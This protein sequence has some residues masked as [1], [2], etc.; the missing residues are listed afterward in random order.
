[1]LRIT[2]I[3]FAIAVFGVSCKQDTNQRMY[4]KKD[5]DLDVT[6]LYDFEK[7]PKNKI[8]SLLSKYAIFKLESDLSVLTPNERKMLPLLFEAGDIMGE[9]FW[10]EA[11]GNKDSL[12]RSIQDPSVKALTIINYGPWERLG[13]NQSFVEG[14][15]PKPEGANFYPADMTKDEFESWKDSTKTSQY[16]M[17]RRNKKGEL[18]SIPYHI[19]F[20]KSIKRASFL[21]EQASILADD[22]G[23]K[24]YLE[25][26]AK[27]LLSDDYR[28]SDLAWME[29]K[30]NRIDV[31]VGPIENYEDHL[32]G[33]KASHECYILIK[34]LDWS[35]KLQRYA[36]FLP[37]LQKGLPVEEKYKKESPGTDS[38]LN[39]YD[40][41]YYQG[42]CNAGSKTIAINLPN[43]EVVQLEKGTRRLQ[44]KN[45]MKAKFEQ[46]LVPI[47]K[48]LISDD[49]LVHV[50][51]DAFFANTMFH[52]VAHGLG[53]KN[54]INGKGT[55]R[56]ALKEHYS[57]LEEGKADMLGLYMIN[58]LHKKGEIEGDI[59]D[60]IVTFMASI[61]RSVR[62][63]GSSAHGKA[64]LIRFNYFDEFKAF[65]KD[66][67]TGKY[68]VDFKNFQRAM[69][70]LS[71][72][73]IKLQGDG[74]YNRVAKFVSEKSVI[75][76]GLKESLD[77]LSG[78]GIPVDLVF[79]Q[80]M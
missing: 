28:A 34:D 1:M 10:M 80:G 4:S 2:T 60:Y 26:R 8:D 15:G 7:A 20:E 58:E 29:M 66:D 13:N 43:D 59:N 69:D 24:N 9:L 19:Y 12:L 5:S 52:E 51:F 49:Q 79:E 72:L 61:F 25:L 44:L 64:N 56:D 68:S 54:T 37:E 18:S 21:L 36:A 17:V 62:F 14:I 50:T 48:N 76:T 16:T 74:D 27:A 45:A 33:Y 41:I 32:F 42:D 65:K 57:A 6:R 71:A 75:P 46:I 53:I 30:E 78:L 77:K 3:F 73:I 63:G 39:A 11:Y 40:V 47:A 55:V 70:S 22:P 31:V 38:E 35:K 67:E 23:L